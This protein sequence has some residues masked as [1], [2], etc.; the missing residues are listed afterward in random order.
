MLNV[1]HKLM[2]L[3]AAIAFFSADV[4]AEQQM[5]TESKVEDGSVHFETITQG[6]ELDPNGYTVYLRD[7]EN[8]YRKS[9][10]DTASV[11]IDNLSPGAYDI[12]I[13]GVA[14]NCRV[15]EETPRTIQVKSG[16]TLN[17]TF[18]IY[19]EY[20]WLEGKLVFTSKRAEVSKRIIHTINLD[21][22]NPQR[23]MDESRSE[24]VPFWSPDGSRIAFTMKHSGGYEMKGSH[25]IGHHHEVD[26]RNLE[27]YTVN[28]DGKDMQRV[29]QNDAIDGG[30]SWSPDGE[31]IAFQSNR[32][33]NFEIYTIQ[34]DGSDPKRITNHSADDRHAEWSPDGA[35]LAFQSNRNGNTDIYTIK[36]D[37]S[38]LQ[39][40][41]TNE[42]YDGNPA[43]S[44]DGSRIAFTTDRNGNKQIYTVKPDGSDLQQVTATSKEARSP[45]WSP[46]GSRIAFAYEGWFANSFNELYMIKPDGT[47]M[48][49]ITDNYMYDDGNPDWSR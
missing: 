45:A 49:R 24:F 46:D 13:E 8:N 28:T 1:K 21:G 47:E 29:T 25:N 11:T 10:S 43:W 9:I 23:V 17:V 22:T 3:V 15:E 2:L 31:K 7:A 16:E 26:K 34:A 30:T 5:D 4:K 48:R 44:P 18:N 33:G 40:V 12:H 20:K 42:S 38:D 35:R 36:V 19:C 27:I 14:Y 37:G 6:K 39:R 32:D 41:T